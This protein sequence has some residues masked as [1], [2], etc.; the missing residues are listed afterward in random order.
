VGGEAK[1]DCKELGPILNSCELLKVTIK[2]PQPVTRPSGGHF[3]AGRSLH[4]QV[5]N[6]ERP[7]FAT[8]ILYAIDILK[9]YDIFFSIY[10]TIDNIF[11]ICFLKFLVIF[12]FSSNVF[13]SILHHSS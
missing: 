4:C 11:C 3:Y 6:H 12:I 2:E 5:E 13:S 8:P 7:K 1:F 10:I 9:F